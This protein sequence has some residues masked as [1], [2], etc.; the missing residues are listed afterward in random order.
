MC[1]C[2]GGECVCW[3]GMRERRAVWMCVCGGG[4]RVSMDVGVG[5]KG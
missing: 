1:V 3:R 4:G 2:G 5:V